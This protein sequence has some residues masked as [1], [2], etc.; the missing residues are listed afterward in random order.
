MGMFILRIYKL[1]KLKDFEERYM[2]PKYIDSL[3]LSNILSIIHKYINPLINYHI[4]H[5]IEDL[6][7]YLNAKIHPITKNQILLLINKLLRKRKILVIYIY[8]GMNLY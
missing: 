3:K 2:M 1:G 8:H 5:L 4:L 7:E 6:K